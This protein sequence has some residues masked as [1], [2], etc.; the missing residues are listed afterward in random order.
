MALKA[1]IDTEI[2]KGTDGIPG[3]D[4]TSKGKMPVSPKRIHT[5][6]S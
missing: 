5:N 4:T 2:K 1:T 6:S 3:V